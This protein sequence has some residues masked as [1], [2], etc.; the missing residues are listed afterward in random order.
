MTTFNP[1][2]IVQ[3]TR[4]LYQQGLR[5]SD[6]DLSATGLT[7][8]SSLRST[9]LTT[10]KP[11][12]S[13]AVPA[14]DYYFLPQTSPVPETDEA[15]PPNASQ[16]NV[17]AIRRDFPILRQSVNGQPLI[18]LDNAA[19]TQ[20]PQA[21]IDAVTQFYRDYNSNVHRGAH[22]LSQRATDAYEATREKVRRLINAASAAEIIFVRSATEA[23]NLVAQTLNRTTWGKGGEIILTTMEHHSNIVPWQIA[24]QTSGAVIRVVPINE[25]GELQLDQ[26]EKLLSPRTRLVA[27]T[28]VS[29]VLGTINPV[30]TLI[31]M[32][33]AHKALV[34]IDGTQAVA[35]LPVDVQRL[36]A[37]FYVFSGHKIYG[38]TGIGV[39]YGKKALLEML[40]PWQGGGNMIKKVSFAATVYN[41]LPYKFEAGTG[42]I[43]G[44]VGL[45]AAV[46]YL[47]TIGLPRIE[48]YEQELTAH[49][50]AAFREIPGLTLFGAAPHKTGVF[51]WRMAQITPERLARQLDQAGIAVRV[52]HHCAQPLMEHY[53]VDATVRAALGIYNTKE[54][55]DQLVAAIKHAAKAV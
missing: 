46:D 39:L 34:L 55:I 22:T 9:A 53:Q 23:I 19:T 40:P 32:A 36:E 21:V 35:H 20:K 50:A 15:L 12:A 6:P 37:D 52:G 18:W 44:A 31:E 7:L 38:P 41:T 49:T 48:R 4:A 10:E 13:D 17:A 47:Q 28:H 27:L 11:A 5:L 43:A 51:A 54:E 30:R 14:P 1:D 33:H 24:Q 42:N 25:R 16:F 2:S 29:N 45:G 8:P 26:Y 3:M